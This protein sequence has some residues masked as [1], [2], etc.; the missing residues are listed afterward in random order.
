MILM[1]LKNDAFEYLLKK[2]TN[3]TILCRGEEIHFNKILL[4][5][6]S[7]V[8][9]AMIEG[10]LG[11]E[12]KSGLVEINDFSPETIKAFHKI[13][14]ENKGF[15]DEDPIIELLMFADRYFMIRLKQKCIKHLEANLTT[16]NIFEVIKIADHIN[17][18]NLLKRCAKFLAKKTNQNEI[19]EQW[20]A[21]Q[22]SH[23][24]CCMKVTNFMLFEGKGPSS[25]TTMVN[26]E[27]TNGLITFFGFLKIFSTQSSKKG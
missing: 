20:I 8:F 14:F 5:I 19:K 17:D 12:A 21:F 7:D 2:E 23:P 10:E 16:E 6:V 1:E 24:A 15:D 4:C 22:K 3:F 13:V 9:K 25:S 18:S 27:T 26:K 11:Q